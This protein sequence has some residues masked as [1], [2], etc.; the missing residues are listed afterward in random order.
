MPSTF[1]DHNT[2]TLEINTRKI[3]RKSLHIWKLN[4]ILLNTPQV[5]E[6]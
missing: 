2:L 5:K 3:S 4:D 6:K 1:S